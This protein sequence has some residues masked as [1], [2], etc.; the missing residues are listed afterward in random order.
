MKRGLVWLAL[1]IGTIYAANYVVERFGVVP[2]GFGLHAPAAVY[3]V[4]LAFTFRDF[5]QEALGV[6]IVV[7][8]IVVGAA[9][10]ALVSP[11]LALA[12]GVAFLVSEGLDLAV[13]TPLRERNWLGAVLASNAV[14]LTIDSLVFLALATPLGPDRM[15]FVPGQILGKAA[16]TLLAL[17]VLAP[18]KRRRALIRGE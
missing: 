9:L 13:Y 3:V 1:Y 15:S 11:A 5:V 10:S 18:I 12:S 8:A 17:T 7:L 4:G 2:V 16:M 6:R 14:G